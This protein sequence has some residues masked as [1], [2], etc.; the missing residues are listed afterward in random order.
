MR[1]LILTVACFVAGIQVQAQNECDDPQINSWTINT[2]G[3]QADYQTNCCPPT[4]T[5][6]PVQMTDS[7]G[8][9]EVYYNTNYV[10]VR[11]N[12]L[13]YFTMGPWDTQMVPSA[14]DV[15]VKIPRT[16]TEDLSGAQYTA[17]SGQIGLAIDGVAI[18]SETTSNSYNSSTQDNTGSGD[19][20]WN[21]DA[22][23]DEAWS[24][25]TSGNGHSNT[26]GKYHYHA[27]PKQLY[28]DITDGHSPII[29]WALDGVPIYGPYGYS[30]SLDANS[31]VVRMES[32]FTLRNITDRTTLPDG[33]VLDAQFHGPSIASYELGTYVEDYEFTATGHLDKHNGRWCVTP[34]YPSG[35]YAYFITIDDQGDPDYPYVVGPEF[36]GET[37][38]GNTIP[39]NASLYDP[40]TCI[41]T[42]VSGVS[43]EQFSFYPNPTSEGITL[44][45]S[46]IDAPNAQVSIV[47]QM[48]QE[49]YVQNY[50]TQDLATIDLQLVPGFYQLQVRSGSTLL[51][52]TLI[53]K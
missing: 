18:L 43:G 16:V 2:S 4:Q 5:L 33:T 7:A 27:S 47:N 45:L 19:G 24:M 25:D 29:G 53:V 26:T 39:I 38:N 31:S 42:G 49:V 32:G 35:V 9:L 21:E 15:L 1:F 11:S 28:G 48:G 34:E 20:I 40:T 14:Q 13:A 46:N 36:Y 50:G 52:E 12:S 10:F 51:S 22:W 6:T 23:L 37:A 44:N 3:E 30:D 41:V 8:I 17:Q